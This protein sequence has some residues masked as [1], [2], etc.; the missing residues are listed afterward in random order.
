MALLI[1]GIF[2]GMLIG[3]CQA[4]ILW[5]FKLSKTIILRLSVANVVGTILGLIL[6]AVCIGFSA[7]YDDLLLL[8]LIWLFSLFSAGFLW[9]LTAGSYRRE[10]VDWAI[11]NGFAYSFWGT[12]HFIAALAY[13]SP[14]AFSHP[15]DYFF[16]LIVV[17]LF[18]GIGF[19]LNISTVMNLIYRR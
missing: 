3:I 15:R 14:I 16:V 17:T 19:G 7:I 9:G 10:K 8:F 18:Y 4:S 12:A 2:Q 1:F 13:D 11:S 5:F 6:P